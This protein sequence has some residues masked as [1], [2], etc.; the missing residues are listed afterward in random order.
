MTRPIRRQG[1]TLIQ[2]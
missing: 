1:I 2:A